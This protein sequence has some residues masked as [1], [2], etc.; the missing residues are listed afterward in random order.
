VHCK[1]PAN[2]FY[3]VI[4]LKG[5]SGFWFDNGMH[6]GWKE[7]SSP[8]KRYPTAGIVDIRREAKIKL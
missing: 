8:T 3:Y 5:G 1:G 2:L 6:T 7:L 4:K